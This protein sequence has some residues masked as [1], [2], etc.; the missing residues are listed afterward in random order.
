MRAGLEVRYRPHARCPGRRFRERRW[1][2]EVLR[3]F[4]ELLPSFVVRHLTP[5]SPCLP[6]QAM[7]IQAPDAATVVVRVSL[8]KVERV[9]PVACP[10]WG[11]A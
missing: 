3:L 4:P 6:R 5:Q 8:L 1:A 2:P 9:W 11:R 7:P 10:V